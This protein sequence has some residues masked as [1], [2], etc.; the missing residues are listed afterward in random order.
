MHDT[1]DAEPLYL[2]QTAKDDVRTNVIRLV[3]ATVHLGN[4]ARGRGEYLFNITIKLHMLVHIGV[5]LTEKVNP[6]RVATPMDEG[7]MGRMAKVILAAAK[8]NGPARCTTTVMQNYLRMLWCRT[9][10]RLGAVAKW[11][12]GM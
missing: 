11:S 2:S 9:G 1:L 5:H 3:A 7:Y 10:N 6:N 4:E 12:V 8:A